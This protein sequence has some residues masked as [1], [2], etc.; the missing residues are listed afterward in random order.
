MD[1]LQWESTPGEQQ[2]ELIIQWSKDEDQWI[3][4]QDMADQA[5]KA[6][7]RQ[8]SS[9]VEITGVEVVGGNVLHVEPMVCVRELVLEA[10]TL[11]SETNH[12]EQIPNRF[13]GFPVHQLNLGDKRECFLRTWKRLFKELK[14]WDEKTTLTWAEQWEEALSGRRPSAIYHYGPVK[15]ALSSLVDETTKTKA[16]DRLQALYGEIRNVIERT[17]DAGSQR[18]E[19]SDAVENYDWEYTRRRIAE[20]IEKYGTVVT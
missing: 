18:I 9:I 5:A 14:G 11:L 6:L 17:E 1:L 16:G 12:L 13:A 19:Y 4:Y 20:L 3:E 8:L 2:R 10:C 15:M 7:K